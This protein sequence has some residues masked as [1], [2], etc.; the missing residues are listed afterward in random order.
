VVLNGDD[1]NVF[2]LW[3]RYRDMIPLQGSSIYVVCMRSCMTCQEFSY[4]LYVRSRG[5]EGDLELKFTPT[6]TSGRFI[7]RMS[8]TF[9]Y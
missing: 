6:N 3:N 7:N 9:L 2:L 5:S 1:D 8:S 4:G